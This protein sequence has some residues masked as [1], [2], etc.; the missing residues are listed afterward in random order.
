MSVTDATRAHIDRLKKDRGDQW[1]TRR[2]VLAAGALALA[3]ELDAGDAG[4]GQPRT[5]GLMKELRATLDDLE[6]REV[7][8]DSDPDPPWLEDLVRPAVRNSS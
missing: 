8:D 3:A 6:P 2:D 5:S 1:G 7:V 4:R